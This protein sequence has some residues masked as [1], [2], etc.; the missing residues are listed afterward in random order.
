MIGC[1]IVCFVSAH[2]GMVHSPQLLTKFKTPTLSSATTRKFPFCSNL[3]CGKAR[4]T[5]RLATLT[6]GTKKN[7]NFM[8][9]LATK[10]IRNPPQWF[11]SCSKWFLFD[12]FGC[13][14]SGL[15]VRWLALVPWGVNEV[16]FHCGFQ[17][18][19]IGSFCREL[20]AYTWYMVPAFYFAISFLFPFHWVGTGV[21]NP[22]RRKGAQ[23]ASAAPTLKASKYRGCVPLVLCSAFT[24]SLGPALYGRTFTWL[25]R[26]VR[27]LLPVPST[28][29]SRKDSALHQ[30]YIS[31]RRHGV[32]GR[33]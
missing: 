32:M 5:R 20:G 16:A 30:R 6:G 33:Y 4:S 8:R 21:S 26:G 22:L 7:T 10:K 12:F 9:Y 27:C 14:R 3:Q 2:D 28:F 13:A 29:M 1:K 23:L 19:F 17:K 25:R 31:G 15:L 24:V 18:D 11:G